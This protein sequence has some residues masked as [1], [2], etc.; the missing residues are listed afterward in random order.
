MRILWP[1]PG[2]V[3]HCRSKPLPEILRV[4]GLRVE[5]GA[6]RGLLRHRAGVRAVDGVDLSVHEGEMLGIVG[7]SGCGKTTLART[8]LGL[9][10]EAAGEIR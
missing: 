8:L 5:L 7:E 6:R 2:T 3:I 9:Q 4:D 1:A 10:Q